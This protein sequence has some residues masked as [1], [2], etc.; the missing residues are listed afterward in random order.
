L[1]AL[2]MSLPG[3]FV[4]FEGKRNMAIGDPPSVSYGLKRDICRL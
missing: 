2:M 4:A 1:I 3:H